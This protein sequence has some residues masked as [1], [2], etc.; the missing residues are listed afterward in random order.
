MI[1]ELARSVL[2]TGCRFS[3]VLAQHETR[4]A[5]QLTILCYHRVLPAADKAAYFAP[6]LV[7]TPA[8]FRVHCETLARRFT[9][10][11]LTDAYTAWMTGAAQPKPLVAITFDDGYQDNHDF[12]AP[13]LAQTGLPA[14]FFAISD[15]ANT[16]A[17]PWYD[18]MARAVQSLNAQGR[19][20][21]A[22]GLLASTLAD[23]ASVREIV[24]QAKKLGSAQRAT[25]LESL[26]KTAGRAAGSRADRMMTWDELKALQR[27]G[28]EIGSHSCT[29]EILPLLD[30]AALAREIRDSKQKLEAALGTPVRTLCYPNGDYDVRTTQLAKESGYLCAVTTRNGS[31]HQNVAPYEL[32]RRFIHEGRLSRPLGRASPTQFRLEISGL[33]DLAY[34]R[35]EATHIP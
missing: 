12:A 18:R 2:S 26:L 13:V 30:D 32:K 31:N 33:A 17:S 23:G 3:T 9:V 1:K 5:G 4:M 14:T 29:H 15:L 19:G 25:L 8:A 7:V 11:T 20:V 24:A 34:R 27:Q 22:D 35:K 6:D 10:L 21:A 16:P 28:H